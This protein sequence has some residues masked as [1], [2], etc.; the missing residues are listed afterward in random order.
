MSL[1]ITLT[2]SWAYGNDQLTQADTVSADSLVSIDASV[3]NGNDQLHALTLDVSQVKAL[4]ISSDQD[5]TLETN[6]SSSPADTIALKANKPV[7]WSTNCGLTNPLGTDVTALYITN[8]SG[9]T[10]A[11][12]LRALVDPTV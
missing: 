1:S 11:F 6:S 5:L 7:I 3:A 4:Y 8:A 12:K 2:R 10:A 9:S